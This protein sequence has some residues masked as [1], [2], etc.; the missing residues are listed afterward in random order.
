MG[1]YSPNQAIKP[2]SQDKEK[3]ILLYIHIHIHI[4]VV[5]VL[6]NFISET[7]MIAPQQ[8]DWCYCICVV[9]SLSAKAPAVHVALLL[10]VPLFPGLAVSKPLLLLQKISGI[11]QTRDALGAHFKNLKHVSAV[12][13]E[14]TQ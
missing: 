8:L 7:S 14:C 13:S 6:L 3:I 10:H 4:F 5:L 9:V 1:V 12:L 2:G 11:L